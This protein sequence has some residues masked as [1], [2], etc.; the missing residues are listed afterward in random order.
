MT[1]QKV[2]MVYIENESSRK[3]TYKKRKSGILKKAYELATLC[4]V[5]IAVMID[6]PY[7]LSPEMWPSREAVEHVVSEWNK[8]S[9]MEK[10]KKM[11]NQETFLQ[12]RIFKSNESWKKMWKENKELEMKEVMFDCLSGKT[13]VTRTKKSDLR[14]FNC[15]I[16]QY[17]KDLNRRVEILKN[18]DSSSSSA[19]DVAT[20][21][22]HDINMPRF[23]TGSSSAGFYDRIRDQIENSLN[24]KHNVKD[25][26]LNKKQW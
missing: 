11:V 14:D 10:T 26:D 7:D 1:R 9:V 22:T 8:L 13:S 21:T 25:L 3:S 2:K 24:V 6:S 23:E 4:D 19:A 5:P 20:T 15:V 16:E 17:L 12:Q 18:H